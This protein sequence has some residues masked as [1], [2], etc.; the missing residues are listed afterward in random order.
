MQNKV[1]VETQSVAVRDRR[2]NLNDMTLSTYENLSQ[3]ELE[4]LYYSGGQMIVD[5][6]E[7][8]KIWEIEHIKQ[9][10]YGKTL[11][12]LSV[13]ERKILLGHIII[14]VTMKAHEKQISDTKYMDKAEDC[15]V[16]FKVEIKRYI[17]D[18]LDAVDAVITDGI[19]VKLLRKIAIHLGHK[20]SVDKNNRII[21]QFAL[22]LIG[23]MEQNS[24]KTKLWKMTKKQYLDENILFDLNKEFIRLEVF[25]EITELTIQKGHFNNYPLIP[26]EPL[27][28]HMINEDKH[29]H[30]LKNGIQQNENV[31]EVLNA[32]ENNIW[33]VSK[34]V[35]ESTY[36]DFL[37]DKLRDAG[38][39]IYEADYQANLRTQFLRT[40]LKLGMG[41]SLYIPA[42]YDSRGRMYLRSYQL[43]PQG[44]PY[45]KQMLIPHK[46]NF[47]GCELT[48]DNYK[49]IYD[50]IC[51]GIA[52]ILEYDKLSFSDRVQ[53]GREYYLNESENDM[54]DGNYPILSHYREML[55]DMSEGKYPATMV[56]LDAT[57][58]GLQIYSVLTGSKAV[59][60]ICNVASGNTRADA[61][62]LLSSELNKIFNTDIFNRKNCKNS[63]MITM[64]GSSSGIEEIAI[65]EN[66]QDDV[67]V[68]MKKLSEQLNVTQDRLKDGFNQALKNIA[69]DAMQLMQHILTTHTILN[70]AEYSWILPDGFKSHYRVKGDDE[71]EI[72]FSPNRKSSTKRKNG[73]IMQGLYKQEEIFKRKRWEVYKQD[74]HS[75]GLPANIIQSIDGYIMREMVRRMNGKFITCIHDAFYCHPEYMDLMRQNYKDIL[76]EI[77]QSNLISDI[78]S[79]ILGHKFEYNK[80]NT[81]SIQDI[82][83]SE[84]TLS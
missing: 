33:S 39:D 25:T 55:N 6:D 37:I 50:R 49:I 34:Y 11:E 2:T 74:I 29:K 18:I 53:K 58:Q 59:A 69:P 62:G 27:K 54:Y 31:L 52:D 44:S 63:L 79:Q 16:R 40:R 20:E 84:F 9:L 17:V 68:A 36:R 76:S 8:K 48:R 28:Q 7:L 13:T 73:N 21:E 77:L 32:I 65:Y 72:S 56:S 26:K 4:S 23:A 61:Y 64:Y 10:M 57:N 3:D 83:Q 51:I 22:Q 1:Q 19:A 60:S 67:E 41:R 35:Q 42:R 24:N 47:K 14:D 75:R 71:Y 30:M 5:M 43:S 78:M 82:Q 45:E 38:K 70:K 66:K 46:D 80:I 15:D 12:G 81:L